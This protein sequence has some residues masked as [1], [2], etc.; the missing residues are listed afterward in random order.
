M[1][2][3]KQ[4]I[5]GTVKHDFD[6]ARG[7]GFI[8]A[9]SDK[10]DIYFR[11]DGYVRR[12]FQ[13]S[14]DATLLTEAMPQVK[15]GDNVVVLESDE[16]KN[17]IRAV[18]WCMPAYDEQVASVYGVLV[19]T[20]E[21]EEGTPVADAILKG[22]RVTKTVTQRETLVCVGNYAAAVDAY[23]QCQKLYADGTVFLMKLPLNEMISDNNIELVQVDESPMPAQADEADTNFSLEL[24]VPEEELVS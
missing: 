14:G 5:T 16:S 21:M 4:Q 11:P 8:Q 22:W 19:A 10:K 6:A 3:N 18:R 17:G 9:S 23:Q 7:Y 13:P 24:H 15:R 20:S 1:K 12:R 2:T